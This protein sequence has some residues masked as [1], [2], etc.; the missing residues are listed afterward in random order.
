[1][2][3]TEFDHD[4]RNDPKELARQTRGTP[5][6]ER[7]LRQFVTDGE[8][9]NTPEYKRGWARN[10]G[11]AT[12]EHSGD[13]IVGSVTAKDLDKKFCSDPT[14]WCNRRD[15]EGILGHVGAAR[16]GEE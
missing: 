7:L 13:R 15:D 10:F 5:E 3:K 1:M 16:K 11:R 14:C 4:R 6:V 8:K 9:G 2:P 12:E